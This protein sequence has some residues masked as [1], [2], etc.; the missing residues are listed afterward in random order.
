MRLRAT[1]ET[2]A[3]PLAGE[4]LEAIWPADYLLAEAVINR[5]STTIDSAAFLAALQ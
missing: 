1:L 5:L 3:T 4:A 2:V